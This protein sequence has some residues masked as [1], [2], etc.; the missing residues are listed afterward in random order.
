MDN[1]CNPTR[2]FPRGPSDRKK[3]VIICGYNRSSQF[4]D[5]YF[6]TLFV[7]LIYN[8]IVFKTS[9]VAGTGDCAFPYDL[10]K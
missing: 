7:R 2:F 1:T 5:G 4:C 9:K 8:H 10:G 6:V 3:R